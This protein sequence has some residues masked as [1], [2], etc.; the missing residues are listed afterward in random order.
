MKRSRIFALLLCLSLIAGLTGALPAQAKQAG[1]DELLY[2]HGFSTMAPF[3][4]WFTY[5]VDIDV[6][7]NRTTKKADVS[8]SRSNYK[9]DWEWLE[10]E[11]PKAAASYRTFMATNTGYGHLTADITDDQYDKGSK[12]AF[13]LENIVWDTEKFNIDGSAGF[14]KYPGRQIRINGWQKKYVGG[15]SSGYI[16][17]EN[18]DYS[19]WNIFFE[20]QDGPPKKQIS[21]YTIK[22]DNFSFV[23]A[24]SSF[25]KKSAGSVRPKIFKG[26]SFA[27]GTSGYM[28]D[29]KTYNKLIKGQSNGMIA[30]MNIYLSGK[31]RGDCRGMSI[32]SD[33]LFEGKIG[34]GSVGGAQDAYSLKKPVSNKELANLIAYYHMSSNF[35]RLRYWNA[36]IGNNASSAD[37]A[38]DLVKKLT[39][40][41]LSP[42][43][44]GFSFERNVGSGVRLS[45]AVLAFKLEDTGHDYKI[46]VYDP[47]EPKKARYIYITRDGDASF[48]EY[49]TDIFIKPVERADDVFDA[50]L[51]YPEIPD[52]YVVVTSDGD[53]E[54]ES[55]G[56]KA[57][58]SGNQK[59]G[60]L[61]VYA[62]REEGSDPDDSELI[63]LVPVSKGK[64]VSIR[65]KGGTN[66]S[67]QTGDLTALITDGAKEM[68]VSADG[69]VKAK[70]DGTE[71]T[72]AVGSDKTGGDLVGTTITTKAGE[73]TFKPTKG[74]ANV[75]TDGGKSD[76]VVSGKK[77]D[78]EF[79]GVDTTKGA[80]IKVK[81]KK[82]TVKSNGEKVSSSEKK[83]NKENKDNKDSKKDKDKDSSGSG[84]K[85]KSKSSGKSSGHMLSE[86][87]DKTKYKPEDWSWDASGEGY[88]RKY[89]TSGKYVRD[90]GL[91]VIYIDSSDSTDGFCFQAFSKASG[92]GKSD[93]TTYD[94]VTGSPN[95]WANN[96]SESK[97]DCGTWYFHSL[98]NGCMIV[99]TDWLDEM[100][101]VYDDPAGV[102]YLV[103][104]K[105]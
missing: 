23:N 16:A 59:T 6:T 68:T 31:W 39:D 105:Y 8:F 94:Y 67:V 99:I 20:L 97:A 76:L 78:Y 4:S 27:Y 28:L 83:D 46:S 42:V 93:Y 81:G 37:S 43:I 45:H 66:A 14:P 51:T 86:T 35:N 13:V 95:L 15:L 22:K 24:Y 19:G 10:E 36:N 9:A 88:G 18:T 63:V 79:T 89:F 62:E 84:S 2:Y 60:D 87:K 55:N 58:I 100:Y 72:I 48:A 38:L 65:R 1:K 26:K 96:T 64:D 74:G 75:K 61:E 54:L 91:A 102:Y 33:L 32:M 70:T 50:E 21:E 11:E 80:D 69:T 3:G 17:C 104:E 7:V 52:G 56:Q 25:F 103:K 92:K 5:D 71:G 41:P 49:G 98:G 12:N 85:S 53:L 30:A 40:K 34:L 47:N 101:G 44:V 57:K 77:G 29:K 73:V 90:D 82:A